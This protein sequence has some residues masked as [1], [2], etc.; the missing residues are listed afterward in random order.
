MIALSDTASRR[1]AVAVLYALMA[2]GG[3]S[4]GPDVQIAGEPAPGI[5]IAEGRRLLEE[6]RAVEAVTAF[7]QLLRRQGAD[8]QALNGLAIAYSELGRADLATEMFSRA[9]TMAPDDAA[10][11]NNIGFSALRRADVM[12]ARHYLTRAHGR[13]GE[14]EEIE[15]NLAR[16]A[17]L[18]RIELR[19]APA[20]VLP[21]FVEKDAT[22]V[23]ERSPVS[24]GD[25]AEVSRDPTTTM[26]DFTTVMDPFAG[27][28]ASPRRPQ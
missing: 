9:L 28:L 26:I 19:S 23:V 15:G 13:N 11:L 16:L 17:L 12:L 1:S 14:L 10:T 4:A 8:L 6:G 3:C 22:Q 2:M 25:E 24:H 21:A 18:E 27:G 5:S 20:F 7:R